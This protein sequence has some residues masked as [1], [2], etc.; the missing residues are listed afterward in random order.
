[1]KPQEV[2]KYLA[3]MIVAIGPGGSPSSYV[4][5]D[6]DPQMSDIDTYQL[7]LG[8][9][10]KSELVKVSNHY[11]TLTQRGAEMYNKLTALLTEKKA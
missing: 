4:W 3:T 10:V 2:T 8:F 9:M 11:I 6:V 7:V 1:M 5:M